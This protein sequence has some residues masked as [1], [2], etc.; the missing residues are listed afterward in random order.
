MSI[1]KKAGKVLPLLAAAL[2][3][4]APLVLLI[5]GALM[6]SGEIYDSFSPVL[7]GRDGMAFW[8]IFPKYPTLQPLIQLLMDTPAFFVMFWN[9]SKQVFRILFG[10]MTVGVLAA[11]AFGR[12]SFFGKKTLF[13]IYMVL[14]IM[15]FQVTMVSSYLVL[16]K[17]QIL[18]T[19]FAII[20]P[21]IFSTFPVFIMSKFFAGIPRS[22]L[23]AA[24]LDGAGEFQLFTRIG[25]PL[26]MP[27][28]ISAALLGFLEYWNA[29][30]QPLTFLKSRELWP[31]TLYLPEITASDAGVS[32][33]A[34]VVML[35]PALLIFLYGQTYLEQG[36]QASGLKE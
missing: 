6:G 20:L 7:A 31:L 21:G 5:S 13:F 15:P 12:F 23:E 16:D 19:H 2:L 14:M 3:A 18:D 30:E 10:Q 24:K 33:A 1:L 4:A 32:L 9:S 27:G 25:L 22:L 11:W 17:F 36:I 29:V 28:I 26:G 8:P 35:M 34:S